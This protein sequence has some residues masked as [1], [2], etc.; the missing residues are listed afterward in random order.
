MDLIRSEVE[1]APAA[2]TIVSV[3]NFP[4]QRIYRMVRFEE[5]LL[6]QS[7]DLSIRSN[8]IKESL[9][10]DAVNELRLGLDAFHS[11]FTKRMGLLEGFKE[12]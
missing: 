4:S 8:A 1:S 2:S 6:R 12:L 9:D 7:R 11:K 5:E 10:D 3:K